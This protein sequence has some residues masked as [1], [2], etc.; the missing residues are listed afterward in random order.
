MGYRRSDRKVRI[1]VASLVIYMCS[2]CDPSG[3][4][5]LRLG[6]TNPPYILDHLDEIAK[7]LAHPR[8]FSFIHIPVQAASNK[9]LDDMRRQYTIQDFKRVVDTLREHIPRITVATDIIC[10][11]PTE[12]EGD[13]E[14]SLELLSEY[15]FPVLHISQFYPR[16]GTPAARMPLIKTQEIKRRSRE[17]T[18]VFESYV[19]NYESDVGTILSV[20]VTDRSGDGKQ[21]K[22]VY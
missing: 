5:M 15:Q 6:M 16:P 9:V 22:L 2:R 11:F 21:N 3:V 4:S 13:F 8:V 12:T 19:K 20:L 10:G 18:K 17:A 7:I 14:E 1:F